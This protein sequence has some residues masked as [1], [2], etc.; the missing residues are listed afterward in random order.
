MG[1]SGFVGSLVVGVMPLLISLDIVK[2]ARIAD[3]MISVTAAAG[4]SALRR[5]RT[6]MYNLGH[7]RGVLKTYVGGQKVQAIL[8]KIT[9]CWNEWTF[10]TIIC[11]RSLV[12]SH[13]YAGCP[14]VDDE[15]FAQLRLVC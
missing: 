5:P 15:H 9:Q 13:V 2:A 7:R 3:F 12:V 14:A 4:V 8:S 1:I 10:C 11:M 6:C